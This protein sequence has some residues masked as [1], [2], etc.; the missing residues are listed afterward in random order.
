MK[1]KPTAGQ[2]LH[3]YIALGGKPK[4]YNKANNTDKLRASSKKGSK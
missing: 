3:K 1:A 2:K 4:D